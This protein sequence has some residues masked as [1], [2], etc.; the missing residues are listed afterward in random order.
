M[1]TLGGGFYLLRE[2]D[3][4]GLVA[5]ENSLRASDIWTSSTPASK[6]THERSNRPWCRST[7]YS[8]PRS[9]G[10]QRWWTTW[11]TWAATIKVTG[12]SLQDWVT[13]SRRV[14]EYVAGFLDSYLK[15]PSGLEAAFEQTSAEIQQRWKAI[16]RGCMLR[17]R[18]T[19][20]RVS[21]HL[22]RCRAM[23]DGIA[24]EVEL[25]VLANRHGLMAAGREALV[26][27]ILSRIAATAIG[28]AGRGDCNAAGV[29]GASAA[30]AG[31]G[32]VLDR[33][34]RASR[35]SLDWSPP[36]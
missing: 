19:C 2:R 13:G 26:G 34:R 35:F 32:A 24:H 17:T 9:R 22:L 1:G 23:R 33:G 16:A 3:R 30:A 29:S 12:K 11:S 15:I 21:G 6:R 8:M 31:T 10:H 20:G 5:I 28:R 4:R 25:T 14:E 18:T 27:G 7:N 36:D